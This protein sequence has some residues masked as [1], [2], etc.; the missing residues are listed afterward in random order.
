MDHW[1]YELT[2]VILYRTDIENVQLREFTGRKS[3]LGDLQNT[4]MAIQ[5]QNMHVNKL[6]QQYTNSDWELN[7]DPD[8]VT[9]AMADSVFNVV[10][11]KWYFAPYDLAYSRK[12]FYNIIQ[13]YWL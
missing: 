9:A 10:T 13:F 4:E 2:F 8:T 5:L 7:P 11:E 1:S 12:I 6:F 3:L